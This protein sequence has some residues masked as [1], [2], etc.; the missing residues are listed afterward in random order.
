VRPQLLLDLV[1]VPTME[2]LLPARMN[3]PEAWAML[4]AIALQ[5]SNL[6]HRRQIKG[7]A[8]GFW[9][10]E[11]SG[12]VSGVLG[13][14]STKELAHSVCV[15]LSVTPDAD[16]VYTAIEYNDH[17]AC[18]FA[19]L[20]LWTLPRPLPAYKDSGPAWMQYID[21]W[22]PG[23]PHPDGWVRRWETAWETVRGY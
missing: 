17:L 23:K 15:A 7:P 6:E 19:R 9:Q 4:I 20:L 12:G 8:R 16:S 11:K 3:T 5:E 10:F 22:R 14:R 13:H 18:A 1:I 21:A 2:E